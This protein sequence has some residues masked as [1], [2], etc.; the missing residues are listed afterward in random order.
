[1]G[2]A[3]IGLLKGT[4]V[5]GAVAWALYAFHH[6]GGLLSYLFAA[7]LGL[8]VG[9][10]CGQA[11]WK[12]ATLW[13]PALKMVFGALVSAGLYA[14]GHRFMP[15]AK[16]GIVGVL[17]PVSL[18]SLTVL[19]PMIGAAYGLFVE[20]DDGGDTTHPTQKRE[21]TAPKKPIA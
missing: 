16:L 5:G 13:T 7:V 1:M 19:A 2:R 9:L 12:A 20:F 21:P 3:L 10:V 4:L 8:F 11:P 6:Q 17:D 15:A 14:L 18:Q